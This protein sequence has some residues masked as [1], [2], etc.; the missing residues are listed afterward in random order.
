MGWRAGQVKA[1]ERGW[2][3]MIESCLEHI[4]ERLRCADLASD[5]SL[6]IEIPRWIEID[7]QRPLPF[8]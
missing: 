8:E 5:E 2:K 7:C 4:M 6:K 1:W 3:K